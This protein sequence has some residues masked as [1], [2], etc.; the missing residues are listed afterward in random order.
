[1]HSARL[2]FWGFS[3]YRAH[4]VI[5]GLIVL[6]LLRA[7]VPSWAWGSSIGKSENDYGAD[8]AVDALGNVYVTGFFESSTLTVGTTKLRNAGGKDLFVVKYDSDGQVVWARSI[9]G[10]GEEGGWSIAVDA[11]GNVYVTGFF[12]SSTL[13]IGGTTLRNA[14]GKDILLVKYNPGGQVVWAKSVGRGGDEKGYRLALDA[15]GNVYV[16]GDFNSSALHFASN[17]LK[18]AGGTDL[19]VVKY[20]PDGEVLWAQSAGGKATDHST[21][22]AVDSIGNVYVTGVFDS[23]YITFD[24]VTIKNLGSRPMD[25]NIFPFDFFLAKY[26]PNGQLI[27]VKSFGGDGEDYSAGMAVDANGHLYVTG[28]FQSDSLSLGTITLSNAFRWQATKGDDRAKA[29]AWDI[30]VVKYD[31]NG[32]AVWASRVGGGGPDGAAGI[33]VDARGNV[34]ITGFF[35]SSKLTF[36][37]TTLQGLGGISLHYLGDGGAIILG[38]LFVAK[39]DS[40][41][42][43]LWAKGAPGDGKKGGAAIATDTRGNAYVVG[44]FVEQSLTLGAYKLPNKGGIDTFVG[45]LE[46]LVLPETHHQRVLYLWPAQSSLRLIE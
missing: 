7:Q 1:M 15:S 42:R 43:V 36:G 11:S 29:Y 5:C 16:T 26:D 24:S 12:E 9:G 46:A 32:Q 19:F 10:G 37:N 38:D 4:G 35:G 23:R 21:G 22:I 6:S 45:K 25:E 28:F 33:A 2:P 40:N 20:N 34:Y 31:P 17:I 3:G 13:T 8:I 39:Y 44:S 14:G 41:G 30:F 18:N 27:W